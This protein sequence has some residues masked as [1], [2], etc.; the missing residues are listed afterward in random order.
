M[1]SGDTSHHIAEILAVLTVHDPKRQPTSW[2]KDLRKAVELAFHIE[3]ASAEMGTGKKPAMLLRLIHREDSPALGTAIL[4]MDGPADV[5]ESLA[6]MEPSNFEVVKV[7]DRQVGAIVT[8]DFLTTPEDIGS[9]LL[10]DREIAVLGGRI[11]FGVMSS[12]WSFEMYDRTSGE[13]P[14]CKVASPEEF[15]KLG[16]TL[17]E[18][19]ASLND[20]FRSYLA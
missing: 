7:G 18:P 14:V 8:A 11:I 20:R 13:P 19:L 5:A 3:N 17:A 4:H 10:T 16:S 9:A 2:D 15:G 12:R 6:R 1:S